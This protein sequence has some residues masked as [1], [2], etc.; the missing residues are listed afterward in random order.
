[1]P[2]EPEEVG[3][4]PFTV[5]YILGALANGTSMHKLA[6]ILNQGRPP[7]PLL[8]GHNCFANTKMSSIMRIVQ[9]LKKDLSKTISW[10]NHLLKQLGLLSTIH[11][12]MPMYYTYQKLSISPMSLSNKLDHTTVS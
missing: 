8:K 7:N 11:K 4:T 12:L 2:Q 3:A 9:F 6:Y 5:Y 1:M 10:G